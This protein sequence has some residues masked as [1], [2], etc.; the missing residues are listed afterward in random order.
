MPTLLDDDGD[1][2][3][4]NKTRYLGRAAHRS[5]GDALNQHA[6]ARSHRQHDEDGDRERCADCGYTRQ[7]GECADGDYVAMSEIDKAH[8]PVDQRKADR[9]QRIHAPENDAVGDL[10]KDIAAGHTPTPR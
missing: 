7:H 8:D 3:R 2:Q 6:H 4:G 1:R 5:E 10:L 9:D